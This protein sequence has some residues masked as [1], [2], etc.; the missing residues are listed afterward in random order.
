MRFQEVLAVPE[1]KVIQLHTEAWDLR[2]KIQGHESDLAN[3]VASKYL[4]VRYKERNSRAEDLTRQITTAIEYRRRN[5]LSLYMQGYNTLMDL[6]REAQGLED[7]VAAAIRSAKARTHEDE[8]P[9]QRAVKDAKETGK[10]ILEGAGA[11][12]AGA[13]EAVSTAWSDFAS[14]PANMMLLLGIGILILAVVK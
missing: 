10:D 9:L 12:V 1:Y 4:D 8:N 6:L 13:G 3:L 5:G 14:N 2:K 7:N 11:A